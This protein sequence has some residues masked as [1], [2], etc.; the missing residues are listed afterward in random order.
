MAENVEVGGKT[1]SISYRSFS[2]SETLITIELGTALRTEI[3]GDFHYS[4]DGQL[5]GTI[6]GARTV[7]Q[8]SELITIGDQQELLAPPR[9]GSRSPG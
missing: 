1:F 5:S 2:F 9:L 6:T 7:Y 4:E 8:P 3:N